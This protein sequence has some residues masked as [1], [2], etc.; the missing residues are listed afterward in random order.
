MWSGQWNILLESLLQSHNCR[1]IQL[2]RFGITFIKET[3]GRRILW[4]S[5]F[6]RLDLI[7]FFPCTFLFLLIYVH[8]NYLTATTLQISFSFKSF[9]HFQSSIHTEMLIK[10]WNFAQ[11][12]VFVLLSLMF[13]S[14]K[15]AHSFVGIMCL[16]FQRALKRRET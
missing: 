16:A 11:K 3:T 1:P 15:F 8:V 7:Y 13:V 14:N 5:F 9:K 10:D 2:F 6:L 4:V 12:K